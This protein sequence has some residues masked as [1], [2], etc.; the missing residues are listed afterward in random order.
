MK[1]TG[2]KDGEKQGVRGTHMTKNNQ[3]FMCNYGRQ[4]IHNGE[5]KTLQEPL[6]HGNN[7]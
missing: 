7:V 3:R 1:S 5:K 6:E 4:T 2:L